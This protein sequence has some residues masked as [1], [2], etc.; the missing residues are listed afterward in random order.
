MSVVSPVARALKLLLADARQRDVPRLLQIERAC[1]PTPWSEVLFEREI[2]GPA[3]QVLV[4]C[5]RG[6]GVP[7][8]LGFVC[9]SIAADE[10]E[11]RNL[12]VHPD[13][14]RRGVGRQLVD[15]VIDRA[16]S[17]GAR[18]VFLEVRATNGGATDLYLSVG[19]TPTGTRRDYYGRGEHAITMALRLVDDHAERA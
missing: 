6:P 17:R 12:A 10:A 5:R 11:I 14:R 16:R 4:A 18:A 15:A 9:W 1:S 3:S 2:E 13:E 7:D 19:F 8:V